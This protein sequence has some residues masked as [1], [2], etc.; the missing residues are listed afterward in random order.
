MLIVSYY[1]VLSRI[2][3]G[4]SFGYVYISRK[5]FLPASMMLEKDLPNIQSAS[6][7]L[8]RITDL[9]RL[10]GRKIFII[11]DEYDS[12]MVLYFL[13]EYMTLGTIPD[14]VMERKTKQLKKEAKSQLIQYAGDERFSQSIGKTTLIKLVL[15]FCGSQMVCS[16]EA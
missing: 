2:I 8:T 12:D 13:D 15:V 4:R 6:D 14:D 9:C 16:D 1:L 3:S 5:A 11:I 7:L 10:S